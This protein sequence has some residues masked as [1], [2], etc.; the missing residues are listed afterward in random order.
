MNDETRRKAIARVTYILPELDDE[1]VAAVVAGAEVLLQT[2]R[3]DLSEA[4]LA[5]EQQARE[6]ERST[7]APKREWGRAWLPA[8][9][10]DGSRLALVRLDQQGFFVVNEGGHGSEVEAVEFTRVWRFIPPSSPIAEEELSRAEAQGQPLAVLPNAAPTE[11]KDVQQYPTRGD[12]LRA[13]WLLANELGDAWLVLLRRRLEDMPKDPQRMNAQASSPETFKGAIAGRP[14]D[15]HDV[16]RAPRVPGEI[17]DVENDG[18]RGAH[19]SFMGHFPSG[20]VLVD[21]MV[22]AMLNPPEGRRS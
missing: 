2:H 3:R 11:A 8:Q 21:D 13:I 9:S 20:G 22:H 16:R 5:A 12:D 14:A 4:T 6:A 19:G 10:V 15:Y 18:D 17:V 1:G 7:T